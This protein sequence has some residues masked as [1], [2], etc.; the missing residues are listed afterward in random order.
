MI[1]VQGSF[2]GEKVIEYFQDKNDSRLT[3]FSGEK[4]FESFQEN[5]D[6]RLRQFFRRKNL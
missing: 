4:I 1:C 3:H 6:L 5:D 2:A